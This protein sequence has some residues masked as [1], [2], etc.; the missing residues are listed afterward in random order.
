MRYAPRRREV[1]SVLA[2]S[3]EEEAGPEQMDLS[4]E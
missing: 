4:P 3:S 1:V 2:G